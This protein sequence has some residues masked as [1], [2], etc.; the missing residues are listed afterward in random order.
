MEFIAG[1]AMAIVGVVALL[2]VLGFVLPDRQRVSRSIVIAAPPASVFQ[3]I[4]D[5]E[6]WSAWSP[7]AQIDPDIQM[8]ITGSGVGQRMEWSSDHKNVGSGSQEIVAMDPDKM[9]QTRLEFGE[10]GGATAQF[11]LEPVEGGTEVSWSLDTRMRE[12]VPL[13]RQPMATFFG[14]MMDK[15]VGADYEK[16]LA[17]LKQVVEAS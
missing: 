11:D 6:R 1:L 4:G 17:K 8:V 12:G 13:I 15:M 7:W 14:F 9:M 2:G 5:F 16:G 10:M 3:H